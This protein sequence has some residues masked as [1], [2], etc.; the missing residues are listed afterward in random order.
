LRIVVAA[1]PEVAITSL[2]AI[3]NSSHELV[4]VITQP[5]NPAGRGMELTET[6][7]SRWSKE[8]GQTLHKPITEEET[9]GI[10][11]GID[12]LITIGYGKILSQAVL[13]VPLKS[14][15]N[16]HFSLL[17]RWRGAAPV[18]RAI[19]AG[20]SV[21]GVTVFELDE[22]MDTGPIYT[23]KRFALDS[24]ISS[25]DLFT[26]LA[27]IGPEALL[28]TLD[29]IAS[30]VKPIPQNSVGATR[31]LKLSREEGRID[32]SQSAEK[33][34]AHVRAF[35]S[36]P[37]AWTEFRETKIRLESPKVSEHVLSP[38]EIKVIEKELY[39]GSATTALCFGFVTS[40]G[41]NRV[42]SRMWLN[43]ARIAEGETFG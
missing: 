43:G 1:T 33:I 12:V 11:K 29:L 41:K 28:E 24:D 9:I 40:P 23:V 25:D 21:T 22:G 14:S 37:G 36:N 4:A 35:T 18:Q 32:W 30:G 39:V 34:S 7:V 27:L 3:L 8:N 42:E 5:D 16:L 31:A 19:E 15:L 2:D 13:D 17:P 10:L 6:A 26:E 20:D 38:G